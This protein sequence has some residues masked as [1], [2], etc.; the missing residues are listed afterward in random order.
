MTLSTPTT[1]PHYPILDGLRGVAAIMVV[2][3]HLCEAHATSHLDMVINHGYLAVDFFFLLSGFVIGYAYD[4]RWKKMTVGDFF[5]RRLIRL[6]PMVI[7]GMI[8][9]A[10]G[11]YFQGSDLW[12][13]ISNTPVWQTLLL[14]LIGCTM[15]PIPP[16][17]DI[18]GWQ[19]MYPLNGPAWS[20]F[21]EYVANIFYGLF[22]RKFSKWL[23]TILV[24]LS[25]IFL[26]HLAL[27]SKQGDIIGGWSLAPEQLHIGFARVMYPFF[28]GLLLFRVSKLAKI[29]HAFIWCS[30]MVIVVFAMPRIGGSQHLWMNAV[31]ESL[32]VIVIFPLVIFLGAS[33]EI[34][35]KFQVRL[36]KFLGDISYPIYITH[37]PL[38]YWYTAWV[39]DTHPG[40]FSGFLVGVVVLASA[41][42]IAYTALK[43]YD[44]PVRKWLQKKTTARSMT[45]AKPIL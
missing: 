4:D 15:L 13:A 35:N 2:C 33:G 20:L 45:E 22:V 39:H 36:C 16:S 29:P 8:I 30:L 41:L 6:Q 12:P 28:A 10:I 21:F 34:K 19:E 17:M 1:K 24:A 31:Y 9:G 44:E 32:S 42:A 37:Y 43:L 11:F 25:A 38:I 26:L 7:I 40:A 23:L 18:R 5:K 14:M 27:T 3:M